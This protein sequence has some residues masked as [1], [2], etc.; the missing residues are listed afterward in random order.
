MRSVQAPVDYAPS[1]GAT[2]LMGVEIPSLF[3]SLVSHRRFALDTSI[4]FVRQKVLSL[5][6]LVT[7]VQ[8]VCLPTASFI[9][10]TIKI[11][12]L[13]VLSNTRLRV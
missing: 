10:S 5:F 12:S 13:S 3:P 9:V 6:P 7:P 11:A 8:D 1:L 4:L 2:S